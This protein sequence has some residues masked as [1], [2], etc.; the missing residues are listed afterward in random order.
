MFKGLYYGTLT[1]YMV[2]CDPVVSGQ[3]ALCARMRTNASH[4]VKD[5]ALAQ[6]VQDSNHML[7]AWLSAYVN[8]SSSDLTKTIESW[9]LLKTSVEDA[10]VQ[11]RELSTADW[12]GTHLNFVG[13]SAMNLLAQKKPLPGYD[14]AG[15]VQKG[16]D[17]MKK[18]FQVFRMG[19]WSVL[20]ASLASA[21]DPIDAGDALWRLREFP[22]PKSELDV[23]HRVGA[24]FVMS[25][26]PSAPWKNDWTTT[27][28]TSSLHGY[29]IFE[30]P[31]DVYRWRSGP[32]DYRID[33]ENV[34]FPGADY[35]HAYWLARWLGLVPAS[36]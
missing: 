23:D 14:A 17:T 27:D 5:I 24:D 16:I 29:P 10:N 2:L 21:K 28:R 36:E 32:F 19:A 31:P 9:S 18:N 33:S 22:G 25:P 12:S 35:L 15:S 34:R 7:A 13:F 30:V 3:E 11:M 8:G 4:V 1:A 26:Y 6:S 20:F